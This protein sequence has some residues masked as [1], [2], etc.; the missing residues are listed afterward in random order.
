[1]DTWADYGIAKVRYD[2]DR[3]HITN[4]EVHEDRGD[5]IGL[6]ED[7]IRSQAL[8]AIEIGKSFVT[9]LM[10]D[11]NKWQRGQDVHIVTIKKEKYIRTDWNQ[12]G[13]DNLENLPE[14]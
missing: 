9:I 14:Y 4:V 2:E 13:S 5:T 11:E 12:T 7:W 10:N 3:M 1:M 6:A 8:A